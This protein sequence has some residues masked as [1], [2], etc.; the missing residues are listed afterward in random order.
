MKSKNKTLKIVLISLIFLILIGILVTLSILYLTK[1]EWTLLGKSTLETLL[2]TLISTCVAY[3]FGI[4]IGIILNITSKNGLK[5]NKYINFILGLIV[6]ILRSV[7]C[8]ILVVIC[9]PW[10]RAWFLKGSGEWYTI[11]LPL[12]VTAFGFASRMVEQSLNE[13][14]TGEIEAFKSLGA[15]DFEIIKEV[16]LPES[17][18][19]LISGVAVTSITLL[20]YTSF[21]YNIGAGG[22]ISSIYTYYSRNTGNFMESWY[23]WVLIIVVVIIVQLMQEA[24]LY[25]AK[26][27]DKRRKLK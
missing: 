18:A 14:P 4:P 9:M 16:L 11:L 15:S 17:K 10:T 23:F 1:E 26:K 12:F 7:P 25:L 5:P 6:N 3:L 20:G 13:V 8:L 27:L 19:S 2:Q 21:A 22:L 24:G